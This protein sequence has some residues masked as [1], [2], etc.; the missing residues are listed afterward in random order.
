MWMWLFVHALFN[1]IQPIFVS[2]I[3]FLCGG[4]LLFCTVLHVCA[5][6][7]TKSWHDAN[8]YLYGRHRRMPSWQ[9]RGPCFTTETWRCRKNFSQ[10]ERSF[11]FFKAALPLAEKIA[12]ASDRCSETGPN[13]AASDEKVGIMTTLWLQWTVIGRTPAH[14]ATQIREAC[15]RGSHWMNFCTDNLSPCSSHCNLKIGLLNSTANDFY[16]LQCLEKW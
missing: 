16:D 14:I 6:L 3:G 4:P 1:V 8:F 15:W 13:C 9:P 7:E 12:A 10:W 5:T 11:F 2:K